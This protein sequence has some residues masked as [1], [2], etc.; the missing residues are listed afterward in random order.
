[1]AF[2]LGIDGRPTENLSYRLLGTWQE[3]LG[4]YDMPYTKKQYNVSF[5]AEA[6]YRFR[7]NWKVTGAYAMDFGHILG[8]NAGFQLTISKSGWF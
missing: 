1:M 3:G 5:M 2:H 8:N 4:T 7:H 6:T